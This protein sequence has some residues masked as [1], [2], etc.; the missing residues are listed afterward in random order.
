MSTGAHTETAPRR[1]LLIVDDDV[2]FTVSTSRALALE[3]VDCAIVHGRAEA[4]AMAATC[5]CEVVLLDIRLGDGD[6]TELARELRVRRP[7]MVLIIMTAYAT[8]DSAVAA[9]KA[10]AYDYLRKPFFLDE[11]LQVL[12]RCYLMTDLRR[13]KLQAQTQLA[14]LRQ[15]EAASQLATGLSHDFR[16]MLAVIQANLA[17]IADRMPADDRLRPYLGDAR[18]AAATASDLVSNLMEFARSRGPNIEAIDLRRPVAAATTMLRRTLCADMTLQLDLPETAV[19]APA[20][21]GQIETAVVNLLINARDATGGRGQ[22]TIRLEVVGLG[23]L[24]ARLS[25]SDN[26]PGFSAQ[27]LQRALEPMFSTKSDGTGL[28]LSVIQ[29][30]ALQLGGQFRIENAAGSGARAVLDLPC[31]GFRESGGGQGS[32]E[33]M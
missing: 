13:E 23:G 29:H 27:G 16:N 22:V 20:D 11:L 26:G 14:L 7:E 33:N 4:L 17:V 3:G 8:V 31:L 10:G 19:L 18:E 12:E 25:V 24:Y 5:E 6:G 1:Q 32:G 9:L 30:M 15:I 28:G 21:F 2:D